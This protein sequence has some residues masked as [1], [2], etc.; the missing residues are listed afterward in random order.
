MNKKFLDLDESFPNIYHQKTIKVVRNSPTCN[1]RITN[2]TTN[3]VPFAVQ[4][5]SSNHALFIVI[6]YEISEY[7]NFF[8][9]KMFPSQ[10]KAVSKHQFR[11]NEVA[12]EYCHEKLWGFTLVAIIQYIM[13]FCSY[14]RLK[15]KI[16]MYIFQTLLHWKRGFTHVQFL[17]LFTF[18]SHAL[19]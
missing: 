14:N 17:L 3:F 19:T 6:F 9:L 2:P 15:V 10:K 1:F 16:V 13:F 18:K 7:V 8:C 12:C 4:K 5:I 11:E